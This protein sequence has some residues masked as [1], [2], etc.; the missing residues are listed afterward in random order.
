MEGTKVGIH[1]TSLEEKCTSLEMLICYARELGGG[2][3][4]YVERVMEIVLPLLKFYFHDGVRLAAAQMIPQLFNSFKL[5]GNYSQDDLLRLWH[6]VCAKLFDSIEGD[7]DTSF[8]CSVFTCYYE[9]LEIIG[10]N[11]MTHNLLESLIKTCFGISQQY[12]QRYQ[13]RM[14]TR[15]DDDFDVDDEDLLRDDEDNDEMLLSETSSA[16]HYTFKSHG[17]SFLPYFEQL[18]PHITHFLASQD[19]ASRQFALCIFDDLIEF[20][21]P[22][23]FNYSAHFL[24]GMMNCLMDSSYDVRQTAC[25]GFGVAAQFGGEAYGP[26]CAKA[27]PVLLQLSSVADGRTEEKI[28]ATENAISAVAKICKYLGQVV[29]ANSII[30]SWFVTL[31]ITED[32]SEAGSVYGYLLEL[33]EM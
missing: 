10:K 28:M 29:D 7:L 18:L 32:D 12:M 2:F 31:P 16:L 19:S 27:V 1:T 11:S 3:H 21:S 13:E 33:L 30:P 6:D 14:A 4:P 22:Q 25:Y 15:Q 9:C 8:Q 24:D 26:V 20:A 5:S 23:S 17:V